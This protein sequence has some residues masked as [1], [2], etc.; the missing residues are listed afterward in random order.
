MCGVARTCSSPS[1]GPAAQASST[2]PAASLVMLQGAWWAWC[3][4][5]VALEPPSSALRLYHRGRVPQLAIRAAAL[6]AL[7]LGTLSGNGGTAL[8]LQG[9]L[10]GAAALRFC[11]SHRGDAF[12]LVMAETMALWLRAFSG[13]RWTLTC[14]RERFADV[15]RRWVEGQFRVEGAMHVPPPPSVP[16][17]RPAAPVVFV[18]KAVQKGVPKPAPMKDLSLPY[19]SY[20]NIWVVLKQFEGHVATEQRGVSNVKVCPWSKLEGAGQCP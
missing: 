4:V 11:K 18:A 3:C 15:G 13:S 7:Q 5:I 6:E 2:R 20:S 10:V 9:K 16:Q 12:R 8:F 19:S 14:N 1:S 17:V